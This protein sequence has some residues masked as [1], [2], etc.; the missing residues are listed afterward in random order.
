MKPILKT[1]TR[2]PFHPLLFAVYPIMAL[3][4]TNFS[5]VSS[6][7]VLKP[8]LLAAVGGIILY[9]SLFL[10][11]RSA[12]KSA[13]LCT[14]IIVLYFTYGHIYGLLDAWLVMGINLGRHRLLLPAYG[15]LFSIGAYF[16]LRFGKNT[17][18][19]NEVLN[20]TGMALV[21]IVLAQLAFAQINTTQ[22]STQHEREQAAIPAELNLAAMKGRADLPDIYLL[23]MDS[24]MREDALRQTFNF[25]NRPFL[26]ELAQ[27][28][29]ILP[30]CT[31]S[32]YAE[33][34]M[35]MSTELNMNYLDAFAS[36]AAHKRA[37]I[38]YL[39]FTEYIRH[40]Q[41]REILTQLGYKTVSFEVYYPWVEIPDAEYY[42]QQNTAANWL[43]SLLDITEF[44]DMLARTT[45]YRV[46]D[47]AGT[48]SPAFGEKITQFRDSITEKLLALA[49]TR[50]MRQKKYEL[51]LNAFNK[52]DEVSRIPGPKFVYL[53]LPAPHPSYVLGP[54]GDYKPT[55]NAIPGYTDT[56]IYLNKRILET[57]RLVLKNS[58][59]PPVII[60]QAD[61]GWGGSELANR[62]RILNAYYLPGSGSQAVYPSI[63]PVNTFRMIFN[64]YFVGSFKLLEDK[65]YYST[66]TGYFDFTMIPPDCPK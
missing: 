59:N 62:M 25:D 43:A 48:I 32:N 7:T 36:Q 6:D 56:I 11:L 5:R 41:V 57:I 65:S 44:D 66:N 12:Y 17:A 13:L 9:L 14:L 35:S 39:W 26:N 33:T 54:N 18:S 37:E 38:D 3:W 27:L 45:L 15:L 20:W 50:N 49:E 30:P 52:M 24:Y 34:A 58:K 47:E 60:L 51:I 28:G 55:V 1:L 29:F 64:Q 63:T 61:H 40:S 23:V 21:C 8:L 46:V 4:N 53:H 31:Q 42:F 16:V 2:F 10:V 19:L 22:A